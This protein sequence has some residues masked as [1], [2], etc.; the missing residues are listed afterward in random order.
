MKTGDGFALID[1]VHCSLKIWYG[2]KIGS[3]GDRHS[4]SGSPGHI[5]CTVRKL[6]FW[7]SLDIVQ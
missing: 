5:K 2:K 3:K 1:K 6:K 7:T 4:S